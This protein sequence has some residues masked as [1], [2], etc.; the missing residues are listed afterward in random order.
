MTSRFQ[1]SM[2]IISL[3]AFAMPASHAANLFT[4]AG[5]ESPALGPGG[6]NAYTNGGNIGGWSVV[7]TQVLLIRNDY[8]ETANGISAFNTQEGLNAVDLTGAANQGITSGVQQS[9]ATTIGQ[10]YTLSFFVGRGDDNGNRGQYYTTPSTVDLSLDGGPRVSYTNSF[11]S[12]GAINWR[13]FSTSFVATQSST[14]VTFFNNTTTNNYAGLD[15]LSLNA[16]PEPGAV[17]LLAGLAITGIGFT[18]RRA[19]KVQK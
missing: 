16:T 9:V 12:P 2:Y 13:Q 3:M 17:S 8:S 10:T 1:N 15:A 6:V 7:G 14:L 18:M 11:A 5:F 19:R 4:N